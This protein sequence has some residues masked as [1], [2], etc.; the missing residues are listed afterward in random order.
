[1]FKMSNEFFF[2]GQRN[3]FIKEAKNTSLQSK[4]EQTTDQTTNPKTNQPIPT[5][6]NPISP[7]KI[8]SWGDGGQMTQSKGH[9]HLRQDFA[10]QS[11]AMFDFLFLKQITALGIVF[12]RS[13][14]SFKITSQSQGANSIFIY[15]F[16]K[17]TAVRHKNSIRN[18]LHHISSIL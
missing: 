6:S 12:T 2:F 17:I 13:L 9:N 5:S 3:H 14:V 16:D 10:S 7:N 15:A 8:N 18:S 11:A 4:K 1:M